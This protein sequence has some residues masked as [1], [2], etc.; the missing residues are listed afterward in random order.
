MSAR[1]MG[2]GAGGGRGGAVIDPAELKDKK[3]NRSN[4]MRVLKEALVY[5]P[6]LLLCALCVLI[7]TVG[8][9]AKPYILE[10]VLDDFLYANNPES[11]LYSV[12]GMAFLY[13][14]A[15]VLATGLTYAQSLL[16]NNVGQSVIKKLRRQVFQYIQ[17]MPLRALDK[18]SA[19]RLITRAT[20]D[21][22]A[23]SQLFSD[24]FINLFKDVFM[25][26][27]ILCA[28]ALLSPK[29]LLVSLVGLPCI[30]GITVAT[31]SLL[32]KNFTVVKRLIGTING[33]FAENMAGMRVVQMFLR[34][35]EKM[36]EFKKLNQDYFKASMVQIMVHSFLRPLMEVVNSVVIS[37]LI[38]FAF[39]D[40]VAAVMLP[41]VLLAFTN[42]VKQFFEPI[43]DLAEMYTTIQS[44]S[45]SANRIYELM[46]N[47]DDQEDLDAGVPV[48]PF[49]GKI[50]FR[51]VWFAYE[52]G[53]WVLKNVSFV[54]QPGQRIA[55]VGTTGSGKTT[56]ISLLTRFYEIQKGQILVDD[57]DITTMKLSQLRRNIAVVLQDVFLFAGTVRDNISLD[58]SLDE[59]SVARALALSQADSFVNELD[60]GLDHAVMERGA[61]FSAGQ[62]QLIS[63]ARAIAHDPRIFVLDEA[64][65]HIDTRTE[66]LIQQSLNNMATDR[67]MI[68]I[69]HRLSTIRS[70]DCIYVLSN[71]VIIE[72]GTHEQL[73]AH[74][75]EYAKLH[76]AQGKQ[77]AQG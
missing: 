9:L 23:L 35:K 30:A 2:L 50:E 41:G 34:E 53:N 19:G 56:I 45:V 36:A 14:I 33:F 3:K 29:L 74:G 13:L 8:N 38:W 47:Q 72:Q 42:Y 73:L 26:V 49:K 40:I 43:N 16:I 5:W 1:G 75:G 46:D 58:D 66:Q 54:I 27:G 21:V 51:N 6:Q 4:L 44:A 12:A 76:E 62:R 10:V 63:F 31:R 32:R 59:K 65:A 61:A 7:A 15:I 69:A 52:P 20:N 55:F 25:L 71:G 64:T 37:A 22:E 77:A 18:I 68:L 57:M 67:T 11:G 48:P 24:V 17:L 70:C 39:E 60:G 28:M